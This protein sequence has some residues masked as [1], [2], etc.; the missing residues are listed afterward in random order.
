MFTL[1]A[2]TFESG[3]VRNVSNITR[4]VGSGKQLPISRGS[5]RVKLTQLKPYTS[6]LESAESTRSDPTCV[7]KLICPSKTP[8]KFIETGLH[9]ESTQVGFRLFKNGLLFAFGRRWTQPRL[10]AL[11]RSVTLA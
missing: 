11:M 7:V 3:R 8:V 1:V 4:W 2:Q 9:H 5:V 10:E 6:Y